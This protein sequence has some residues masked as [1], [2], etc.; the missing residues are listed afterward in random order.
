[1][2]GLAGLMALSMGSAAAS[3]MVG[4]WF[5]DNDHEVREHAVDKRATYPDLVFE[6]DAAEEDAS[7]RGLSDEG[8]GLGERGGDGSAT[9]GAADD[10]PPAAPA[11]ESDSPAGGDSGA[12]QDELGGTDDGDSSAGGDQTDAGSSNEPSAPAD[13][14]G[15]DEGRVEESGQADSGQ[16]RPSPWPESDQVRLR[17]QD[18]VDDHIKDPV[19]GYVPGEF[20]DRDGVKLRLVE[21]DGRLK[22]VLV[23]EER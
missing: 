7:G 12:D 21:E 9:G 11:D 2:A 3:G 10:G 22:L 19:Q 5:L 6:T 20:S 14:S 4:V 16:G 8:A 23:S 18:I 13:D 17:L 1:M 15:A